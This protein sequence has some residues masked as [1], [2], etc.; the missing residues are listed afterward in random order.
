MSKYL[1]QYVTE[2]RWG[3]LFYYTGSGART[4]IDSNM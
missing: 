2:Q 1:L 3:M 4:A